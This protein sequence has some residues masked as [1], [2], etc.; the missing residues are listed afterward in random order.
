MIWDEIIRIISWII[1]ILSFL[2]VGLAIREF[3]RF[4]KEKRQR[5]DAIVKKQEK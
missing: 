5:K 1:V 4:I 3:L 2:A